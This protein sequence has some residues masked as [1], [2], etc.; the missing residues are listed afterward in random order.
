MLPVSASHVY[1]LYRSA[2]SEFNG[3][4]NLTLMEFRLFMWIRRALDSKFEAKKS[5]LEVGHDWVGKFMP[6][7]ILKAKSEVY[8]VPTRNAGDQ[9]FN[10]L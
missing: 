4:K 6:K 1:G 8:K 10:S 5:Q 9:L 2:F 7:L 3:N